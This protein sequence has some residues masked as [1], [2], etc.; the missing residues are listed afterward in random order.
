MAVAKGP[1][2]DAGRETMFIPGREAIKLEPRDPVLYFIQAAARR[3]TSVRHRIAPTL[4]K[5]DIREAGLQ[6]IPGSAQPASGHSCT[7]SER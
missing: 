3:G 6:E 1:D 5:K 7:I 4:R 2:R